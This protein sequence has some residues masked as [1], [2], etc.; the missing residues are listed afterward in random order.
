MT[1]I[2][3]VIIEDALQRDTR[4]RIGEAHTDHLGRVHTVTYLA[5][6]SDDVQAILT[7]RATALA[8]QLAQEEFALNLT[9]IFE[10]RYNALTA[11]HL[12]IMQIRVRLRQAFQTANQ[13]EACLLAAYFV[14]LTDAQLQNVFGVDSAQVVTLRQRLQNRADRLTSVQQTTGE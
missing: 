13:L 8:T 2:S 12:T 11:Q 4:R 6:R 3:S 1:I 5:E 9:A 14:T 7:A 10:Q